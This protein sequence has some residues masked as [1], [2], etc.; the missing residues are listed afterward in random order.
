MYYMLFRTNSTLVS[1]TI[2]LDDGIG[3]GG[4]PRGNA[5]LGIYFGNSII[6]ICSHIEM[7]EMIRHI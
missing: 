7:C 4:L 1:H 3:F 2:F 6:K 5:L